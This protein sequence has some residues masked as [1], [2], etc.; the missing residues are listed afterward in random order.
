MRPMAM[1]C[2]DACRL[3]A[4]AIVRPR[5]DRP[6]PY[7][8]CHPGIVVVK[9]AQDGH[10]YDA[11]ERLH[12]SAER[13]I[14]TE[15]QVRADTVVVASVSLKHAAK[16][17]FAKYY[18]MVEAFPT[19]RADEP[20]YMTV[21][22]WRAW[23]DRSVPDAHGPEPPGDDRAVRAISITNEVSRRLIPWERLGYLSCN[24]LVRR[25]SGDIGPD[26]LSAPEAQDYEPV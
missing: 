7:R 10:R 11:P 14:L 23:R 24:P 18:E 2:V 6:G 8:L 22:P 26:K 4:F 17:R 15:G 25:M 20:L 3:W 1:P 13:C 12:R 19:D 9:A 5:L 16:M 21:L